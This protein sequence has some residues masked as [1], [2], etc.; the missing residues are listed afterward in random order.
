MKKRM[1]FTSGKIYSCLEIKYFNLPS[2]KVYFKKTFIH[3]NMKIERLCSF[4]RHTLLSS[5]S[6][7]VYTNICRE[8]WGHLAPALCT[9][10][11]ILIYGIAHS[12]CQNHSHGVS[13][14]QIR[15]G[16]DTGLGATSGHVLMG[17]LLSLSTLGHVP[18]QEMKWKQHGAEV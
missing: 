16:L 14:L 17:F 11:I 3:Q 2:W 8:L 12:F 13:C 7:F 18:D 4:M 9:F 6:G 10:I 1:L 5:H 15:A